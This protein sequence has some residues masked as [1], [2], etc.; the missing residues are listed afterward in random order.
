LLGEYPEITDF[1]QN[2]CYSYYEMDFGRRL[3]AKFRFNPNT[4]WS[5]ENFPSATGA[6]LYPA[7]PRDPLRDIT[8]KIRTNIKM[9]NK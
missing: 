9:E 6:A 1:R 8:E 2:T 4:F 3:V 5:N 7:G